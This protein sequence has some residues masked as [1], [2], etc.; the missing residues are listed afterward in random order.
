[1]SGMSRTTEGMCAPGG[2]I[3]ARNGQALQL[4][5]DYIARGWN[6]VPIPLAS[7]VPRGDDWQQR[8]IDAATAQ[9]FFNGGAQNIGV[10]LG[11]TSHGLTD[12]DLDCAEAI[13]I[14]PY[15]LP[16]TGAI[17]GRAGKRA[18]HWLYTTDLA[19]RED[20][21]AAVQFKTPDKGKLMI[22]EL[23][24]GG[25]AG[26]QTV[27]PGS[28][29]DKTGELIAWEPDCDREPAAVDG[30]DLLAR[31]K[32][33]AAAA[34]IARCWP[35]AAGSRHDT[36]LKVGGFFARAGFGEIKTA[37]LVE[38]I[39]RAAGDEEWDDRRAAGRDAARKHQ[40]GGNLYGFPA[41]VETAGKPAADRVAEWIGYKVEEPKSEPAGPIRWHG[42]VNPL[43]SRP[44]LI[45]KIL[46]EVGSGLVS[47]QWGTY[48]TFVVI[49]I[50]TSVMSA[51]PFI[52]FAVARRGGVLF[53]AAEGASE[54]PARIEAAIKAKCPKLSPAPF[55]WLET[56]PALIN[57]ETG[58]ILVAR[59]KEAD[60]VMMARWNL[61][62]VLIIIDTIVVGAGFTKDGQ[63]N[64]TAVGQRIMSTLAELAKATR[65]FV[66]GVD[67]FGKTI[68]TGTRG[69]SAKEGA[70]DV[71]L[72]LLG[73][74]TVAG[75][76]TNPRL[77][78][79]KRRSGPNGE[80]FPFETRT[81]DLGMSQFG[82]P[83][84]SLAIEWT[85]E[86]RTPTNNDKAWPKSL[87]L[88]QRAMMSV[89]ADRGVNQYPFP[90]GPMVRAVDIEIVR[91]EF[92]QSYPADG[93]AKQKQ[94]TTRKAFNRAVRDA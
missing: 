64:D 48:K 16:V 68:E 10:M 86:I 50:A 13:A 29:H 22:C 88:L 65:T 7:K 59:A 72:A 74:R 3:H 37:N 66:L 41:L 46:P 18:S 8:I 81:V 26:A 23:R 5:L 93:A 33:V 17:F 91:A 70:A 2:N 55:A 34:L 1:M 75:K 61:P 71:V 20:L 87:R 83:V 84:S 9:Q 6:P 63:D 90:N 42:D 92:Y 89:L 44:Q 25:T 80:E 47:G 12:I 77:A 54:M 31:I 78:L 14:A 49:D 73:E 51:E 60:D 40:R 52:D 21:N 79:R 24:I 76:V 11:P 27:F 85:P 30:D 62:L 94:E 82:E 58:A 39:A 67:H 57:P 32:L 19:I 36:A 69:S 28:V 15:V 45:N 4:A 56:C 35:V 53:I 43:E 38:A